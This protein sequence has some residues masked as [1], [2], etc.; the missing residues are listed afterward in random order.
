MLWK[1]MMFCPLFIEKLFKGLSVPASIPVLQ[2]LSYFP[3]IFNI[4]DLD[5]GGQQD[6]PKTWKCTV[7]NLMEKNFSILLGGAG[8][9]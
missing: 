1:S 7:L 4:T 9:I 8:L 5:Y 6:V 3:G 2:I